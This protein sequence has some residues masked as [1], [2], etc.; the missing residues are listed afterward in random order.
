MSSITIPVG[1]PLSR[2]NAEKIKTNAKVLNM[3]RNKC[4]VYEKTITEQTDEITKLYKAMQDLEQRYSEINKHNENKINKLEQKL[5]IGL[6]EN[7]SLKTQ[8][9]NAEKNVDDTYTKAR[10]DFDDVIRTIQNIEKSEGEIMNEN[11]IISEKYTTNNSHKK[12]NNFNP[13][14]EF[15]NYEEQYHN[16]QQKHLNRMRQNKKKLMDIPNLKMDVLSNYFNR[17][18]FHYVIDLYEKYLYIKKTFDENETI[19]DEDLKMIESKMVNLD[20]KIKLNEEVCA[21]INFLQNSKLNEVLEADELEE[22]DMDLK[23]V[24]CENLIDEKDSDTIDD[25]EEYE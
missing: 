20:S 6:S 3:F 1:V 12:N 2:E 24:Q 11:K 13:D 17:T 23:N 14:T 18:P 9:E 7:A 8:L 4:D 5:K 25:F 21:E 10:D 19:S 22:N 16:E 15:I